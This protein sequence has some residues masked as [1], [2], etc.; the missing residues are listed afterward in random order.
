MKTRRDVDL[1]KHHD[2]GLGLCQVAKASGLQTVSVWLRPWLDLVVEHRL[3][4]GFSSSRS[5][6]SVHSWYG[7]SLNYAGAEIVSGKETQNF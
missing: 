1:G 6:S 2:G 3:S 4:T 7:S 5:P